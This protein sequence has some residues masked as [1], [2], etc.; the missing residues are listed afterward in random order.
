[1]PVL[2]QIPVFHNSN[3]DRPQRPIEQPIFCRGF[4][5]IELLVVISIIALLIALLLPALSR[6]KGMARRAICVSYARSLAT[7]VHVYS[8][9][10]K[11]EIPGPSAYFRQTL[12]YFQPGAGGPTVS[13]YGD[14]SVIYPN[15]V[16]S[17]DAHYC[18]SG[19]YSADTPWWQP[20]LMSGYPAF[21]G[22]FP[23]HNLASPTGEFWGP[24]LHSTILGIRRSIATPRTRRSTST[25]TF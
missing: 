13:L 25:V 5:L 15:Y 6:A 21:Y 11:D 12:N 1:M 2:C 9:D 7:G 17:P 18:P 14:F 20:G 23:W 19:P 8:N 3:P 24:I 4:T 16:S 22:N 10:H